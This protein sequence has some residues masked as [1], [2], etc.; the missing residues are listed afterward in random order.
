M[1]RELALVQKLEDSLRPLTEKG[2]EKTEKMAQMLEVWEENIDLI[3]SSPLVRAQQ[4]AEILNRILRVGKP[5]ECTELVPSAPPQAFAQWLK[6]HAKNATQLVAVGHEPQLSL[7][8]SWALAGTK[9]SFVNLKK[10][11]MICLEFESFE[12]ITEK[13]AELAWAVQPKLL[14]K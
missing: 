9:T 2:R 3:L 10:S 12:Q 5:I 7:F 4:T 6:Y 13:T 11:G 1:D 8:A 14:V